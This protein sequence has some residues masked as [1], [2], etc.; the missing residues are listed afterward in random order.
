M[1]IMEAD[2]RNVVQEIKKYFLV[3]LLTI[4]TYT[5]FIPSMA[6]VWGVNFIG[7]VLIFGHRLKE[8]GVGWFRFAA[9]YLFFSIWTLLINIDRFN[10]SVKSIGTNINMLVTPIYII[11]LFDYSDKKPFSDDEISNLFDFISML[12]IF[13]VACAWITGY[14]DII[15][16]LS[17]RMNAYRAEASGLFYGKNIYGAFVTLS[18]SVDLYQYDQ[19]GKGK[20]L[21]LF[22][23]KFVAVQVSFSRAALLQ[24][25]L[26][27]FL[28]LWMNRKRATLEWLLIF[29]GCVLL[30]L[31]ILIN[32]QVLNKLIGTFIRFEAGDAGRAA[33]RSRTLSIIG[34]SFWEVIFGVGFSGLD[35]LSLDI[36]NTYFYIYFTGGLIK[37]IFFICL[38][39]HLF[40]LLKQ[41]RL[42]NESL[43]FF[44]LAIALSYL[45]YAFFESISV[46]ELGLLNYMFTFFMFL[47]PS[48]YDAGWMENEYNEE[49]RIED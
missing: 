46:F 26:F 39:I 49:K 38:F 13:A 30:A 6:V 9:L 27:S 3:M 40:H 36:D 22:A 45:V 2:A 35:S 23:L 48:G 4:G 42:Y 20:Y 7:L 31:V 15:Q 37:C 8:L 28:F 10:G 29:A 11:L 32:Q 33:E 18:A 5:F 16:V 21:G 34:N 41:I 47:I 12:G 25:A 44:S 1:D 14:S 43:A 24:A 17:G 19:T